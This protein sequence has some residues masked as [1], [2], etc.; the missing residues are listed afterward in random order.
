MLLWTI[1][2]VALKSL[3]AN[4][5]RSL[6]AMLGIII[7]VGAVISML[8]LGAGAQKQVLDRISA[9]G[10]DLLI[11]RPAQRGSGGVM[12]GTSQRL[13]IDDAIA[14]LDSVKDVKQVAP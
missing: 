10:T 1:L 12:S 13:R 9:M 2:K 11:V 14:V 4:K 8:A 6:L 7:G 5:L 3:K